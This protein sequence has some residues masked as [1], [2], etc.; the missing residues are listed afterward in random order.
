[1]CRI[2]L[3]IT[4]KLHLTFF[5]DLYVVYQISV[6]NFYSLSTE[7]EHHKRNKYAHIVCRLFD[8]KLLKSSC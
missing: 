5:L 6:H 8:I 3:H 7:G 4:K 2:L 1:M